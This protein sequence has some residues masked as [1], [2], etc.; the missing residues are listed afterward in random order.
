MPVFEP[1]T[2]VVLPSSLALLLHLLLNI[3]STSRCTYRY[4]DIIQYTSKHIYTYTQLHSYDFYKLYTS[5][6]LYICVYS[7]RYHKYDFLSAIL[8]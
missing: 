6:K 5:Y 7:L 8:E 4:V 3:I 2:M 1:V